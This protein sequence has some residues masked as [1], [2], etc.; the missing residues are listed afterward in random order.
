M[1]DEAVQAEMSASRAGAAS[2]AGRG[3]SGEL[4]P[5]LSGDTRRPSPAAR[6]A[7]AAPRR[8]VTSSA[9]APGSPA[10]WA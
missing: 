8:A 9:G 5:S 3:A 6:R 10:P 2:G 1:Q 7:L 4:F